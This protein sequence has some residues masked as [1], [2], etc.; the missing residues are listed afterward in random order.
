MINATHYRSLVT[1]AEHNG[2]AVEEHDEGLCPYLA[3][4]ESG[5]VYIYRGL[6]RRESFERL[7]QTLRRVGISPNRSWG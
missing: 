2:I 5:V 7:A 1:I 6:T 3:A 4:P